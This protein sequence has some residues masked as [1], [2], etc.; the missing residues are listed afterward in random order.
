MNRN[1]A[2]AVL[3]SPPLPAAHPL[4][5][6]PDYRTG[7]VTAA[8]AAPALV[9]WRTRAGT[10]ITLAELPW[11]YLI[12]SLAYASLPSWQDLRVAATFS[13]LLVALAAM[14]LIAA[15]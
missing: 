14:L 13:W 12:A 9:L 8:A 6:R 10:D 1:T 2:L 15:A 3:L 4:V 5:Q 11:T 7:P